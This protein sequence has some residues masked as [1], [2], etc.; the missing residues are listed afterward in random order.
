MKFDC[1]SG[2]EWTLNWMT[3]YHTVSMVWYLHREMK[4]TFLRCSSMDMCWGKR[5]FKVSFARLNKK[6][7]KQF[8]C[9]ISVFIKFKG[10]FLKK[11][12][13]FKL[14]TNKMIEGIE[15]IQSVGILNA[16][17]TGTLS[18]FLNIHCLC[19]MCTCDRCVL[20]YLS[21]SCVLCSWSV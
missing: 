4:H 20:G 21:L 3:G 14:S 2:S 1:R 18:V 16:M 13:W 6:D 15:G 11:V 7:K 17:K 9:F 10:I 5:T 8:H 19:V 12:N